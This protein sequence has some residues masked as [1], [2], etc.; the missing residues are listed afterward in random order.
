MHLEQIAP[1]L[2]PGL[3]AV[4]LCHLVVVAVGLLGRPEFRCQHDVGIPVFRRPGHRVAAHD[5]GDPDLRMRR[6]VGPRPGV[7]VAI[8]IVLAFPAE[9][10]VPRPCVDDEIV[11]LLKALPVVWRH[12][13]VRDAFAAGSAHPAG[14]QAAAGNHVDGCETFRQPQRVVPDRQYVAEQ[15]DLRALGDARQD[16][17]LEVHELPHAE[18]RGMVLV[19]HQAVEPRFL[20][21]QFFVEVAVIE[22]RAEP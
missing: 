19:Q 17:G 3:V 12:G 22:V 20:R 13:I 18:R 7:H 6:L 14:H 5:P 8:V 15:H 16:R 21:V 9:R 2:G 4:L 1:V 10:P 11:R